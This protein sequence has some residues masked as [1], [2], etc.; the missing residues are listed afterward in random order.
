[1]LGHGSIQCYK[2]AKACRLVINNKEGIE[3]VVMTIN[4]KMRTPKIEA[5][6]RLINHLNNEGVASCKGFEPIPLLGIDETPLF[7]N[8]WFAGLVEGDGCFAVGIPSSSLEK[9]RGSVNVF[10]APKGTRKKSAR[11]PVN[12]TVDL[13]E[14]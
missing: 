1:V 10:L 4:G 5:L 8:A 7:S 11:I 12:Q 14:K 9:G 6:H 3:K 2:H 13:W